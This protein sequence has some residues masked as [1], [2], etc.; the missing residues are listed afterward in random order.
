VKGIYFKTWQD[1]LRVLKELG[2]AE[3][4]RVIKPQPKIH[5]LGNYGNVLEPNVYWLR[6]HAKYRTDEIVYV[7][8]IWRISS[9]YDGED[10]P[11][12]KID[13]V[14]K[15]GR[16]SLIPVNEAKWKSPLFMPE[17]AARYFIEILAVK[18]QRVQEITEEEARSE[19]CTLMTGI[20]AGGNMGL[21][22]ARYCFKELWNSINLDY[23]WESNPFVFAYRFRLKEGR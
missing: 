9:H 12:Y 17:W 23:P 1:K 6:G 2:E 13:N 10:C 22:S 11:C 18:A 8:E 16:P 7:K 5:N 20:T 21:A 14:C 15:C 3:T 4:R 19:G